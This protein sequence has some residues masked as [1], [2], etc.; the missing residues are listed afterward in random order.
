MANVKPAIPEIAL[1]C[2]SATLPEKF[3]KRGTVGEDNV[4]VVSCAATREQNTE[5]ARNMESEYLA[6]FMVNLNPSRFF[7]HTPRMVLQL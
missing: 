7:F 3:T 4:A 5:I 6:D 2:E 1:P